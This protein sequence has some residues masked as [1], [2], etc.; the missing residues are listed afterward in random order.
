MA[1]GGK[2]NLGLNGVHA[3]L[4]SYP[5]INIWKCANNSQIINNGTNYFS[6]TAHGVANTPWGVYLD[7]DTGELINPLPANT[8]HMLRIFYNPGINGDPVGSDFGG[9]E[10]VVDFTGTASSVT[11]G[12]AAVTSNRVGNRIEF[13]WPVDPSN[14]WLTFTGLTLSDPPQNI[15]IFKASHE[16]ALDAGEVF[17]PEYIREVRRASG[18]VRAM[19]WQ[20]TNN[21]RN[22]RTVADIPTESFMTWGGG[23][24]T[25]PGQKGGM[26]L[27]VLSK[28]A[29]RVWSHPWVCIP[30]V[31]GTA[32]TALT[33]AITAANP[34]VVTTAGT[35]PFEDGDEVIPYQNG[36]LI[37]SATVTMTIASPCVVTWNSH[38]MPEDNGVRFSGGTFP[39]GVVAG[40]N[41]YAKN[42]AANTFE[43]SLTPGGASINTTGS[44]SGTHTGFQEAVRNTFVVANTSGNTFELKVGATDAN[45]TSYSAYSGTG[46]LM[47][48]YDLDSIETQVALFA[49]HFRDNVRDGLVTYYEWSNECW[50]AIF[51]TFHFCAAQARGKFNND[52]ASR[53]IG[54]L[55]AHC[56]NV[57]RDTYGEANRSKWKGVLASQT[58]NTS[59]TTEMI[60]GVNQYLSEV[61]GG[62]TITDLFDHGAITGYFGQVWE[63]AEADT[64]R[65]LMEE[66]ETRFNNEL[67][68]DKYAYFSR[69]VN[70]DYYDGQHG[71]FD[72]FQITG[73]VATQWAAQKTL[74][75]A[76]SLPMIQYEGG[77]AGDI[78]ELAGQADIATFFEWFQAAAHNAGDAANFTAMFD[79][80]EEYGTYPAKFTDVC[81]PTRFGVFG[82]LRYVGD[83]NA[84]WDATV[85]YNDT[86]LP[87]RFVITTTG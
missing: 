67:E 9:Q 23:N 75:D 68:P 7:V 17:N 61:G 16:A 45:F 62:L 1:A 33:S 25:H 50:N 48:P 39:T 83:S 20:S 55:A 42:I 52:N 73:N 14:V 28:I 26:P 87:V 8:T 18:I 76:V 35:N 72:N 54:Y 44:Q 66:S 41:Y 34:P 85:E 63:L 64:Y 84:V 10:W 19:D 36:G 46:Y 11:F 77:N 60:A 70:E 80:W 21:N 30:H 27:T 24:S 31:L 47:S 65:D 15:R 57:I 29:N 5:F 43:I 6:S 59:I 3:G 32:K 74:F 56:M 37:K 53:M 2:I 79:L 71:I 69:I 78:V 86:P 40:N 82:G 4:Q 12:G 13:T 81:L 58:F 38:G 51:D 22:A 49:A